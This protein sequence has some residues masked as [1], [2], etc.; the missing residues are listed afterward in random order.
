MKASDFELLRDHILRANTYFVSGFANAFSD[1]VTDSVYARADGDLRPIFPDDRLAN[2]FYLR[3]EQSETYSV[4]KGYE[5]SGPGRA[6][7]LDSLVI[8]LVA[9]V[10][11]ADPSVLINN[12]RNTC[13]MFKG[14]DV[15]PVSSIWQRENVVVSEM[16]GFN[17]D[18]ITGVLQRLKDETMIKLQLKVSKEFIPNRCIDNP[19]KCN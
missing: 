15:S 10:T 13:L 14:Y 12:L 2:Y 5:D 8:N 11:G 19:C 18:T 1:T 16:K 6:T 17:G 3:N 4:Q 9:I 7:F